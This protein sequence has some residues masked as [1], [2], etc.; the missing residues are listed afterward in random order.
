MVGNYNNNEDL[1]KLQQGVICNNLFIYCETNY[2]YFIINDIRM[3]KVSFKRLMK[4]IYQPFN[5]ILS[6]IVNTP[7]NIN[8]TNKPLN[9]NKF[10][11]EI[12]H[13]NQHMKINLIYNVKLKEIDNYLKI[14]ENEN[15]NNI[16]AKQNE[17]INILLKK[18]EYYENKYNE[19]LIDTDDEFL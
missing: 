16:I 14:T 6:I 11:L 15:P 8:L 10:F 18:I 13:Y 1:I 9:S 5:K 2:L 3:F 7:N 4:T 17:K 12:H 19:P